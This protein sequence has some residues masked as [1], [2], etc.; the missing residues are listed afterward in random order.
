MTTAMM[1]ANPK[2]PPSPPMTLG[3]MRQLGPPW[4]L[5]PRSERTSGVPD[6]SGNG[7]PHTRAVPD[8][9]IGINNTA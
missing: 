8:D 1:A 2:H 3:N 9:P 4:G 6:P 5:N 7:T